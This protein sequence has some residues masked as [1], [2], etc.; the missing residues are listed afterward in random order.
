MILYTDWNKINIDPMDISYSLYHG[1]WKIIDLLYP[2]ICGGCAKFGERWCTECDKSILRLTEPICPLCGSPHP[3][4]R[5]CDTCSAH[6][7]PYTLLRSYGLYQGSLRHAIIQLKYR[8]NVGMAEILAEY[9]LR[10]YNILEMQIDVITA[11]PLS[12]QRIRRRGYN[13][14]GL[15]AY[16]LALAINKPYRSN[17]LTRTRDTASQVNL[18]LQERRRN[19]EGAFQSH[20]SAVKGKKVLIIDDVITTG[21]TMHACSLALIEGGASS[22]CALTA[23]RAGLDVEI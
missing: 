12:A 10:L 9:L 21:A 8:N 20:S 5:L 2:P 23:A 13:Q 16:V 19:V 17:L 6:P 14:A 11:V 15:I 7:P 4:L 22:V 1:F 3:G 18:K